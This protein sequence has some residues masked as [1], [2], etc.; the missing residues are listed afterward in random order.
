MP[1][2]FGMGVLLEV[3]KS[4]L[5]NRPISLSTG[6]VNVIWQGDA[7][8]MAIRSLLHCHAPSKLVNV[9]GPE[10]VSLRWLASEFGK[11]FD[12]TPEFVGQEQSAAL[13]SNAAESFR[14][15]GY[16][17]VTLKE[18]VDVTAQWLLAGGETINKPTYF[19]ERRG[20]Y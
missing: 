19:Q 7:N 6:H 15:F 17:K 1:L 2:I 3:A 10:T 12:K 20:Q 4:V 11:R 16:P 13:L 14:L 8:E 18:M 9:T 5:N